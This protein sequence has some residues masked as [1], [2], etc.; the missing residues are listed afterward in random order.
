MAEVKK[1]LHFRETDWSKVSPIDFYQ[2]LVESKV[3]SFITDRVKELV[4]GRDEQS[5]MELK[6]MY[7]GW[8]MPYDITVA[9][10]DRMRYPELDVRTGDNFVDMTVLA[11]LDY[12]YETGL[13]KVAERNIRPILGQVDLVNNRDLSFV[14]DEYK[15]QLFAQL[16]RYGRTVGVFPFK[17][18]KKG[19]DGKKTMREVSKIVEIIHGQV[20]IKTPRVSQKKSIEGIEVTDTIR[21]AM[22]AGMPFNFVPG[23]APFIE[24][25][26][27]NNF[28]QIDDPVLLE[29]L[30]NGKVI[31]LGAYVPKENPA[32]KKAEQKTEAPVQAAKEVQEE[33]KVEKKVRSH[34]IG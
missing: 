1:E 24:S 32:E 11:S 14:V 21:K 22:A 10:F 29:D 25:I 8:I 16:E 18:W 34:R 26:R 12:D 13:Y 27:K 2:R 20:Y 31:G 33:K 30:K 6:Q 3:P 7:N 17:E 5:D 28:A 15:E 9:Q 19:E 4:T 23:K